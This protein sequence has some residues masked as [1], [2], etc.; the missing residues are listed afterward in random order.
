MKK[1]LSVVICV[2]MVVMMSVPAFA[3]NSSDAMKVQLSDQAMTAAVGGS[4][5]VNAQITA[6]TGG[7][8][9]GTVCNSANNPT[10]LWTVKVHC[11]ASGCASTPIIGSAFVAPGA[12]RTD[13][14]IG[15]AGGYAQY[16]LVC[17]SFPALTAISSAY[18]NP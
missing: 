8:V 12:C 6:N 11:P 3:Y 16:S 18:V 4:G 7:N 13:E 2:C 15:V 1:I 5:I 17:T 9:T 14:Y 10:C